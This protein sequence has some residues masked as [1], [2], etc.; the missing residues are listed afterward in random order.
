MKEIKHLSITHGDTRLEFKVFQ[1]G[2]MYHIKLN[3][4]EIAKTDEPKVWQ[5][6][7]DMW[8]AGFEKGHQIGSDKWFNKYMELKR[9]FKIQ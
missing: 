5:A 8:Y 6:V 4:R 2:I 1:H 9:Q 7:L 3:D